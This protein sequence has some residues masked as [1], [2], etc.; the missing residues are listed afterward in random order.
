MKR[1]TAVSV[2]LTALFAICTSRHIDFP[3]E[4]LSSEEY[5]ESGELSHI[6]AA[7]LEKTGSHQ[8]FEAL[9][10][11]FA[12]V[13]DCFFKQTSR[14]EFINDLNRLKANAST[15]HE[16]FP[17]YC[18]EI[19]KILPCF[20]P[21]MNALSKC[22]DDDEAQTLHGTY[23]AMPE[24]LDL[25]CENDGEVLFKED[26]SLDICIGGTTSDSKSS[27]V[28]AVSQ[29][30]ECGTLSQSQDCLQSKLVD[31]CS[32]PSLLDV[33]DFWHDVLEVFE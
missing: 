2:L 30:G 26:G 31:E 13:P 3:G 11:T 29:S 12:A 10:V 9:E 19:R 28:T 21:P 16:F 15:R 33:M 5:S 6:E 7:C 22:V 32:G 17:K 27:N 24:A 25:L 8:A 14:D 4:L 18:P 20:E 1:F 23:K